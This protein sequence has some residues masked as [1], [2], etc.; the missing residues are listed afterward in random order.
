M[1][2]ICIGRATAW[3]GMTALL[4]FA[5]TQ[6][7]LAQTGA[8]DEERHSPPPSQGV[9]EII[10]V[11][12]G[13]SSDLTRIAPDADSLLGTAGDVNDPLKAL[14]SLPGVTFGGGDLD[15]PI[16]R[17]AGPAD[18]LFLIDGIPVTEVFH[19]LSD[20]IVSPNVIRTFDLSSAA[21]DARYGDA[22]GGV[23]DIGLRDPLRDGWAAKIDL[24]QLKSGAL[25]EGALSDEVSAYAS[26]R[27]NLAHLFLKEFER[28]ND[29]LVFQM[30]QSSDYTARAI[31]RGGAS[32]VTV[33]ALGSWD[34]TEDRPREGV[35]AAA[36][37]GQE[38]VR[39]LDAQSLRLRS[40][41]SADTD[42][43][44]VLSHSRSSFDET[45]ADGTYIDR[46]S[47]LFAARGRIGHRMGAHS[48]A[49]GVN[50]AFDRARLDFRGVVPVCDSLERRCGGVISAGGQRRSDD[51]GATELYLSDRIA[52]G[53]RL[54]LDLGVH[55]AFDHFLDDTFIEPR[56]G[57]DYRPSED[58]SLYAR[59]GR[60]HK[61]PAAGDL[62]LL[63]TLGERQESE[64][65][66][67]VLLGQ[68]WN[69]AGGWRLQTEAW[70]KDFRQTEF[71]GSPLEQKL[72]GEAYGLDI[73][74]ARPVNE[75]L[76]GWFALSLADGSIR[77]PL[78]GA[79]LDSPD[80]VPVS[81]TLAASYRFDG[82]WKLGTKYR[83]QSGAVYTPLVDAYAYFA[84][85]P[86]VTRV[87]GVPFSERL[88]DY[89]RLDIRLEKSTEI[90]SHPVTFYLD[91]LNV[92][93]RANVGSREY[94]L[95]NAIFNGD[96]SVTILPDDEEG[97]PFF[98]AAGINIAF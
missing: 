86:P 1:N 57:L 17:G 10:V 90:G 56:I 71:I 19:E 35:P 62:L 33:T 47:R 29:V 77:D 63:S 84:G 79:D 85:Q 55:A 2:P 25:I 30:P 13:A 76:S 78:T 98:V 9:D 3:L 15:P 21:Y 31:W 69:I 11:T 45:R 6:P 12:G 61:R 80:T 53:D 39:R 8:S 20:S 94:P 58:L 60:H 67:Q 23:I 4:P 81:A 16:I 7:V 43:S 70:Y 68:R 32:D 65:S 41:L 24:S 50:L 42:A 22:T 26:Y 27:H 64:R 5:C 72:S 52:V 44:L 74:V 54:S 89:H 97:I 18:N 95:R 75:R 66:N 87:Y 28:G 46:G 96:D 40:D 88:P 83:Y 36:L 48:L 91:A 34:K 93:D 14:L 82:G 49:A 73:L 37:L 59:F 51:F 38:E 92:L